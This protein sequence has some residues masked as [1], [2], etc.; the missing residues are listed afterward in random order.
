MPRAPVRVRARMSAEGLTI[1]ELFSDAYRFLLPYFQRGYAWQREHVG[2]LLTD[3]LDMAE[4]DEETLGWYPL[5]SIILAKRPDSPDAMVADGHQRLITLTII[6]AILRDFERDAAVK[7]RLAACV[8]APSPGSDG[9]SYRLTTTEAA[10]ECLKT[11]V[12]ADASTSVPHAGAVDDRSE[13]EANIIA[14]RDF[15]HGEIT[16]LGARRRRKLAGFLLD[17]CVILAAIVPNERAASLLFSTMH[18]TGLRPTTIDLFKAQVLD[19]VPPDSRDHC[20]VIW[21]DLEARLGPA[22]FD[23]LLGHIAMLE[24]REAPRRH[25]HTILEKRFDLSEAGGA[26]SFIEKHLQGVGRLRVSLTDTEFG[27]GP[28]AAAIARRLQYLFW[29]NNHDTWQV[30]MLHWLATMGAGHSETHTFVRRLERLAWLLMIGADEPPRRVERYL[31]LVKA[32]DD[33]RALAAGSPLDIAPELVTGARELLA[34]TNIMKRPY[35]HS[36]LF[37]INGALEGDELVRPKPLATIEHILPMRPGARSQWQVDFP[38]ASHARYRNQLGNLTLLGP[39]GQD[40]TK[41]FDFDVKRGVFARC[42]YQLTQRIAD[43]I[44]WT[45]DHVER[46]TAAMIDALWRSW[47]LS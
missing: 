5:G 21:E 11:Y 38:G 14:N 17:D 1:A 8:V 42:P 23:A 25:V 29:I 30:P 41:N 9:P 39:D 31:A 7:A 33:G 46:R 20:C 16:R 18:D 12:Q 37:R 3:I 35:K 40:E 10:R 32:I 24:Q 22:D 36:V 26:R 28:H 34:S 6:I 44:T 2:R 47:D 43:A 45:P 27:T 13:S 19:R 15:L 4:S